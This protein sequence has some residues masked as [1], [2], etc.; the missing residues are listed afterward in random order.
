MGWAAANRD[1]KNFQSPGEFRP[2]RP[3]KAHLTFGY[4]IHTCPGA[5]LAR[6]ELRILIEELLRRAPDLTV[7]LTDPGDSF[8]GADY[9]YLPAL[10]ATFTPGRQEHVTY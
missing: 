5:A 1:P 4:G 2:D 6:M 7:T 9:A 8:G 10:P 3:N